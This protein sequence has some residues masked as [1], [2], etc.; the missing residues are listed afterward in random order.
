LKKIILLV[1]AV[2]L[3]SC[4]PK[5]TE[6]GQLGNQ[7][8]VGKFRGIK[9]YSAETPVG[10][11]LYIGIREDGAVASTMYETG[12]K[13]SVEIPVIIAEGTPSS[14]TFTPPKKE[15]DLTNIVEVKA[16]LKEARNDLRTLAEEIKKLEKILLE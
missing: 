13:G 1:V 2:L 8:F 11:A 15:L 16:K 7:S 14:T 12:G 5:L 10:R 6:D 4:G 9:I 3:A